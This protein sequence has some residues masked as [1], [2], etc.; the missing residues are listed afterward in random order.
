MKSREKQ[1]TF[2]RNIWTPSSVS[3]NKPKKKPTEAGRKLP[4][5]GGDIFLKNGA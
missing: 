5:Y 1:A 4:E 2:R 3:N